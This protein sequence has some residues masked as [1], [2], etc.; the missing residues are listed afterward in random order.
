MVASISKRSKADMKFTAT[1]AGF[2][3]GLAGASNS[4]AEGKQHYVLFGIQ[5]DRQHPENS[6]VYFEYDDQSNGAVN[7]VKAISIGDRFVAFKLKG[8]KSVEV[9]C[10][11]PAEEWEQLQRGIRAVFPKEMIASNRRRIGGSGHSGR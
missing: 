1:E 10:N 8:G 2:E 4:K 7:C 3:D 11:V 5:R 9:N 6:G